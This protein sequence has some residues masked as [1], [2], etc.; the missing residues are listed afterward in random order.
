MIKYDQRLTGVN[1]ELVDAVKYASTKIGCNILI[2]CGLRT[3]EEQEALFKKGASKVKGNNSP[4]VLGKALDIVCLDEDGK[5]LWDDVKLFE[6][7]RKLIS[8]KCKIKPLIIW[9]RNHFQLE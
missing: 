1:Q 6:R 5:C 4:H 7:L 9:D 3:I 8:E 2:V